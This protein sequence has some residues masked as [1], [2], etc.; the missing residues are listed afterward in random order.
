VRC[1]LS[2]VIESIAE[3][4]VAAKQKRKKGRDIAHIR[5]I[6]DSEA[7]TSVAYDEYSTAATNSERT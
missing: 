7:P 5:L 3:G 1:A 2:R 6:P 4:P